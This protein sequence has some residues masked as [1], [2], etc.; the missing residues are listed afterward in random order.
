M[1][2]YKEFKRTMKSRGHEVH[3]KGNYV[4]IVPN[5][6]YLGYGCGFQYATEIIEGFEDSLELVSMDH[7]NTIIYSARFKII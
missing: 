1:F 5:N 6:N 2:D 4:T 7:F 3:K